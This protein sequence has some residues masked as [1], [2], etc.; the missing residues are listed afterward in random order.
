MSEEQIEV[1]TEAVE[2]IPVLMAKLERMKVSELAEAHF[3]AHG[4]WRGSNVGQVVQVW[5]TYI[6]TEGDHR[7]SHVQEWVK[8][9]EKTLSACLKSEIRAEDF[10]DDRLGIILEMF[11]SD[12]KW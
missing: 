5:L 9:R 10:S 12:E 2:D 8:N 6:L 1:Q 4:N 11:G 3:E 7:L